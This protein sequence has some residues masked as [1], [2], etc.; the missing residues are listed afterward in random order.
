M[1]RRW[2]RVACFSYDPDYVTYV[3]RLG[4]AQRHPVFKSRRTAVAHAEREISAIRKMGFDAR[5]WS[6]LPD[7]GDSGHVHIVALVEGSRLR[8]FFPT[9]YWGW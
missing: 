9:E 1:A 3:G 4:K 2:F 6:P 7:H 5:I 8:R